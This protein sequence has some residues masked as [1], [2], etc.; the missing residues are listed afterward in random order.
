[1]R[2]RD[3]VLLSTAANVEGNLDAPSQAASAMKAGRA[4]AEH[5]E[6]PGGC[7]MCRELVLDLFRIRARSRKRCQQNCSGGCGDTGTNAILLEK[8]YRVFGPR[9][10]GSDAGLCFAPECDA[11][12]W[13]SAIWESE[14]KETLQSC[15][16]QEFGLLSVCWQLVRTEPE[17]RAGACRDLADAAS[18]DAS[19]L[20]WLR[21]RSA[22]E[23]RLVPVPHGWLSDGRL[24]AVTRNGP[25]TVLLVPSRLLNLCH[26]CRSQHR[27]HCAWPFTAEDL[28][29]GHLDPELDNP[30]ADL[31]MLARRALETEILCDWIGGSLSPEAS[32]EQCD[33]CA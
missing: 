28:S 4:D 15:P 24:Y 13:Q 10:M 30:S 18:R 29:I 21:S 25:Y 9:D 33:A 5:C 12:V 32:A 7:E 2:R 1:M 23:Q 27:K 22:R 14:V 19:V 26:L 6:H 8:L 20:Q 3:Y 17:F 16:H 31:E 11:C